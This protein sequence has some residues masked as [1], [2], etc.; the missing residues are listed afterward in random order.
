MH[1]QIFFYKEIC[2]FF[3]LHN[4]TLIWILKEHVLFKIT[5]GSGYFYPVSRIQLA[6][7]FMESIPSISTVF[8]VPKNQII[9]QKYPWDLT[10]SVSKTLMMSPTPSRWG[11]I[12]V[13]E[14]M[15]MRGERKHVCTAILVPSTRSL[16]WAINNNNT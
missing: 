10:C 15:N 1:A 7:T 5:T 12:E 3:L 14:D 11:R 6:G 13:I 9:C 2:F 16:I 4:A 8:L